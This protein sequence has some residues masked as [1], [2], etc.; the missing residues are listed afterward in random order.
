MEQMR[1][2]TEQVVM[3]AS[4]AAFRQTLGILFWT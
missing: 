3:A 2:D 1:P 4:G